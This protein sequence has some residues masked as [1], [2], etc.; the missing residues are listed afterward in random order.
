MYVSDTFSDQGYTKDGYP[1]HVAISGNL[2][3][4]GGQDYVL[5]IKIE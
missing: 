2:A 4:I 5:A 1:F 3:L